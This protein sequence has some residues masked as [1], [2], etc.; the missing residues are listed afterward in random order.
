[1]VAVEISGRAMNIRVSLWR[2]LGTYEWSCLAMRPAG[3]SVGELKL[4]AVTG[5]YGDTSV[6]SSRASKGA[7]RGNAGK[8]FG[9]P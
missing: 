6:G 8:H 2:E 4:E 9:S 5:A 1:M 3:G 7:W